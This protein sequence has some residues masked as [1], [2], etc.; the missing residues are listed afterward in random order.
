MKIDKSDLS[1]IKPFL[2]YSYPAFRIRKD[3]TFTIL[4]LMHGQQFVLEGVLDGKRPD[5]GCYSVAAA[6]KGVYELT[7]ETPAPPERHSSY[8]LR[9]R[10]NLASFKLSEK[11]SMTDNTSFE[12]IKAVANMPRTY[13]LSLHFVRSSDNGPNLRAS[14]AGDAEVQV[15]ADCDE[16]QRYQID[17]RI[18]KLLPKSGYDCSIKVGDILILDSIQHGYCFLTSVTKLDGENSKIKAVKELVSRMKDFG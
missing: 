11:N 12:F 10:R 6:K 13:E 16:S 4:G 9:Q 17:P 14:D 2:A 15:I 1:R 3:S 8:A 7:L 18:V 5:A